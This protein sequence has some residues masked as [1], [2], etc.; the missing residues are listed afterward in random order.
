MDPKATQQHDSLLQNRWLI[1]F[2]A[3]SAWWP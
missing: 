2:L 1:L 3:F